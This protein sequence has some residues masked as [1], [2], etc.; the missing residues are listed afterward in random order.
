M[1]LLPKEI[2]SRDCYGGVMRT[3]T[4]PSLKWL[5]V[6]R[7]RPP[8]RASNFRSWLA[9]ATAVRMSTMRSRSRSVGILQPSITFCLESNHLTAAQSPI[10]R[11]SALNGG[12]LRAETAA[13]MLLLDEQVITAADEA[14]LRIQ[15]SRPGVIET[16]AEEKSI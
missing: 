13:S 1:A 9:W 15:A 7:T 2:A 12:L 8:A 14:M 5:V 16:M 11:L 3:L 4:P 10:N 6:R